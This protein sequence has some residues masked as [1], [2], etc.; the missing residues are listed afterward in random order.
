MKNELSVITEKDI[1]S[2][3]YVIRE[4]EVMLDS[5]LAS[6]Y[7]C[8]NGTK[9][10]NQAVKN[11][12]NKFP[13]R[14]AFRINESEA[15][16]LK[17]KILT[18]KGGSR[19]GHTVFTEQGVAMLATILKTPVATDVSIKIMDAF[20]AMRHLLLD[21]IEYQK[22]LFLMQNKI[23]DHDQKLLEHESKFNE[24]FSKFDS[25]DYLKNKLI[26]EN[27]IYDAY[28]FLLDIFKKAKKELIIIDNYVD[29]S[30]LD[31]ICNLNTNVFVISS[32][33]DEKLIKKYQS[34]YKNLTI[35]YGNSFHDRFIII[36]KNSVYHLGSSLKDLGK[37]ICYVSKIDN[38]EIKKKIL[39]EINLI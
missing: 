15:K 21:N 6:L 27:H 32:N 4:K 1:K 23:I 22:K 33:M 30:L 17:S 11:N 3:I 13:E 14:F 31:L 34:Q 37:K 16:S 9:E 20:V 7:E 28:S 12:P 10:I 35:K 25:D 38:E 36:D 18:S 26:C 5:D 2:K 24:I 8:K 19:K 29:K 39:D